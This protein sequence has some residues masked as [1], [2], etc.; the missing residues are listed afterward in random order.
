LIKKV[1]VRVAPQKHRKETEE[2]SSGN[3]RKL[4]SKGRVKGLL[5]LK[6]TNEKD[7]KNNQHQRG[8]EEKDKDSKK[9]R[10]FPKHYGI[11]FAWITKLT[12][13]RKTTGTFSQEVRGKM[14]WGNGKRELT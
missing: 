2:S 3:K 9:E 4:L 12:L 11:E 8:K 5:I 1:N 7:R 10:K 6:T 14:E 13:N